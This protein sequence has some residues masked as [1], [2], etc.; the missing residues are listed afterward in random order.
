MVP[1]MRQPMANGYEGRDRFFSRIAENRDNHVSESRFFLWPPALLHA[2]V[3]GLSPHLQQYTCNQR[4]LLFV[5]AH[6]NNRLVHRVR[7]WV[8]VR[9][10]LERECP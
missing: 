3:T 8:W 7:C 5:S 10:L 6:M 9:C 4:V 1:S 2:A